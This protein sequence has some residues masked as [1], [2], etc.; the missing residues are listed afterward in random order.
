MNIFRPLIITLACVIPFKASAFL[1]Y[2]I[3]DPAKMGQKANQI[4][5][6]SVQFAQKKASELKAMASEMN[7]TISEFESDGNL[8][9]FQTATLS[10][11][12][13]EPA[14]LNMQ[15]SMEQPVGL[16]GVI[17]YSVSKYSGDYGCSLYGNQEGYQSHLVFRGE[18]NS[19]TERE[20]ELLEESVS[21]M[22]HRNPDTEVHNLHE[23][24]NLVFFD[25]LGQIKFTELSLKD[26][27]A[28]DM[29]V[30][31]ISGSKQFIIPEVTPDMTP[32]AKQ[33]LLRQMRE[34]L[35]QN[36]V[37][38]TMKSSYTFRSRSETGL[39][40]QSDIWQVRD[41]EVSNMQNLGKPVMTGAGLSQRPTAES[42]IR[43][44][45]IRTAREGR[46]LMTLLEA[47][48]VT[49]FNLSLRTNKLAEVERHV[50]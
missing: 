35:A 33:T 3:V 43:G 23:E 48:L 49:E 8:A 19:S 7:S 50:R 20:L 41:N 29:Y 9:S 25:V 24:F 31:Y 2:V 26:R 40:Q 22:D 39:S 30:E 16:C 47:S 32:E 45:A 17:E 42:I 34:Y 14:N 6:D 21:R 18:S 5:Q 1:Y 12:A 15:S 4:T 13:S 11:G 27:E 36:A 37:N 28:M 38:S 44:E 46:F 10:A